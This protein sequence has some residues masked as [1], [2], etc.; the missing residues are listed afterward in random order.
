MNLLPLLALLA[1]A[2]LMVLRQAN[3]LLHLPS[4]DNG[5]YLY[6]GQRLLEGATAYVD[7][8]EYKPPGIFYLNA[9]GLWLGRGSRWGVWTL[10]FTAL[11]GAAWLS[12]LALRP[13]YGWFAATFGT[14]AWLW[15][16]NPILQGGNLTEE[17]ALPFNFLA[18]WAFWQSLQ[19]PGAKLPPF[20]VGLGF[21]GAFLFRPNNAGA[22]AVMVLVWGLTALFQKDFRTLAW[23]LAWS[24]LAV[25]LTLGGVSLYFVAQGNFAEMFHAS[26]LYALSVSSQPD[27]YLATFLSGIQRLGAPAGL[28]LLGYLYQINEQIQT[29]QFDP[30]RAFLLL[31]LPLEVF[32]SSL[33]GLGYSHYYIPWMLSLGFLAAPL[34]SLASLAF[35]PPQPNRPTAFSPFLVAL[36]ALALVAGAVPDFHAEYAQTATRLLT[37]RSKGIE[38]DSPLAAYIRQHTA[39]QD[40]LLVWGTRV[41]INFLSRREAVSRYLFYPLVLDIPYG[42]TMSDQFYA[43]LTTHPPTLIVD[44][45]L[46][47]QDL[48]PSL[49]PDIRREQQKS[50]KLWQTLPHNL[51]Q[52]LEY[53]S[54]HYTFLQTIDGYP[55][56]QRK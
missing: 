26:I 34:L 37:E 25:L 55:V 1:L 21:A 30:W 38:A 24:G 9:L 16:L 13:R 14:L 18:A 29:R 44:A 12:F 5:Y 10:E 17:Y 46:M 48:V 7:V 23:R 49:N 19:R 28:L 50:G 33:S 2:V 35:S 4:L 11:F 27:P 54:S 31:L 56:Y 43:D 32:L 8:W 3:P 39:P 47:N 52:T 41:A 45:A 15:A 36:L 6:L 51:Q 53:I 40:R 42:R 20:G 22:E